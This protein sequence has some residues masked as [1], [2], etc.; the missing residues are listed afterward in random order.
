MMLPSRKRRAHLLLLLC[1]SLVGGWIRCGR[2]PEKRSEIR[3]GVLAQPSLLGRGTVAEAIDLAIE[4]V[5]DA[6][7]LEVGGN[8]HPVVLIMED[9][10]ST[11]EATFRAAL[12]LINQENVVA[13]VGPGVSRDAI[14]AARVAEN[15][16]IPMICPTSTHPGTTAGKNYVFRVAFTDPFQ[17]RVLARFAVEEL[18]IPTAA[19]L[20]DVANAYNRD[21]ATVFREVFEAAGGRVVAWESYTTGD[22]DFRAQL[23]RIR[24]RKP[25]VLFLP[26]FDVEV[27]AQARQ[28][29]QLGIDAILL[30]SD[31]WTPETLAQRPELDGAFTTQHWHVGVAGENPEA[32]SFLR[33]YRQAYGR[34]PTGGSVL[35]YDAVGLLLQA[36]VHAGRTDP[37]SIRQALSRIENYQGASG[38]ITYRGTG[39][40]PER[41]A[42][43]VQLKEGRAIFHQLVN[44]EP[45]AIRGR[46]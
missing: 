39:G 29:R 6:G 45:H 44:P 40:D 33:A 22:Q 23:I 21:I 20:Y 26:N 25:G 34:N 4:A 1:L 31:A 3:I 14:P 11:P 19:V 36:M 46:R 9:A 10:E 12:K 17:G 43:I 7:G 5:N 41:P 30:G 15:A 16:H 38:T 24:N 42:V 13:L 37:E 35:I 8:K 18:R 28:A 27:V 32:R 2:Q